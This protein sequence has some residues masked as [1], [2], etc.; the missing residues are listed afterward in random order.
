[1]IRAHYCKDCDSHSLT[2]TGHAGYAEE[3]RDIVCAAVSATVYNLLGYLEYHGDEVDCIT[4]SVAR[5]GVT[6]YC[7]GGEDISTVFE[8][9]AIGLDQ[10]S[11]KYPD[12]VQTYIS[13]LDG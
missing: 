11:Q 2:I 1:M 5:G 10:I 6:I 7:E 4:S 12:H 3:G 8:L 9:T 13:G